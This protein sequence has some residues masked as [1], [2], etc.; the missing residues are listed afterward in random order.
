MKAPLLVVGLGALWLTLGGCHRVG[1]GGA[2]EGP[3]PAPARV[4]E[5]TPSPTPPIEPA[6]TGGAAGQAAERATSARQEVERNEETE[7]GLASWYGEA[8]HGNPTASG[9]P[10][11]MYAMTAAHPRLDFGVRVEVENL[12]NGRTVI[13]RIN[14]RGPHSG[15]RIIDLSRAAAQAL[16]FAAA[17]TTQVEVR[18]LN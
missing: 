8:L 9:E 15:D 7:R 14:D 17:G 1:V 5:S 4:A 2:T 6:A 13:V 11:D 12:A 16:G 3:T 10:F 18:L